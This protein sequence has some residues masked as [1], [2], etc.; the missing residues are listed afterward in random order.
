[1]VRRPLTSYG[2][3]VQVGHGAKCRGNEDKPCPS[4][5]RIKNPLHTSH[6]FCDFYC[7]GV[8]SAKPPV[9]EASCKEG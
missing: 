5:K 6:H 3:Q 9:C 7:A 8:L 4:R 2:W 1:M